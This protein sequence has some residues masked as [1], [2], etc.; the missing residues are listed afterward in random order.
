MNKIILPS[1]TL[2]KKLNKNPRILATHKLI[3]HTSKTILQPLSLH[4][5][6]IL[7]A[8]NCREH[9]GNACRTEGG[10]CKAQLVDG[11]KDYTPNYD[12]E[13]EPLGLGHGTVVDT[14]RE[15]RGTSRLGGLD[16]LA[17]AD[18]SGGEGKDGRRVSACVAK[19]Y[20]EHFDDLLER[21]VS[22]EQRVQ[23]L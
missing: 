6:L 17:E 21:R 8:S 5:L 3:R 10:P 4:Q 2:P 19:C 20:R 18:G 23:S 13:S 16:D 9:V 7:I 12:G 14:L 22:D 11:G 1:S 15:D